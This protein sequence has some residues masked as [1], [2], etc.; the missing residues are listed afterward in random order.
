MTDRQIREDSSQKNLHNLESS[1]DSLA[2]RIPLEHCKILNSNLLDPIHLLEVNAKTGEQL[3]EKE[4]KRNRLT[5]QRK[6]YIIGIVLEKRFALKNEAVTRDKDGMTKCIRVGLHS[7]QLEDRYFEGITM[8][9]IEKLYTDLMSDEVFYC[10]FETFMHSYFVDVD[11]KRD[12]FIERDVYLSATSDL[13][14][15]AIPKASR[16]QGVFRY[17]NGNI[18]FNT[19]ESGSSKSPFL[20][21]YSK[22][23]ESLEP[24]KADF[25]HRH[26]KRE[27]L[28]NL[29][30]FETTI[31]TSKD[32]KQLFKM[33]NTLINLLSLDQKKLSNAITEAYD[34]NVSEYQEDT[35]T[36][37]LGSDVTSLNLQDYLA[38]QYIMSELKTSSKGY[39]HIR[40]NFVD[41]Y[42][43]KGVSKI[44]RA[45]AKASLDKVYLEHLKGQKFVTLKE[46]VADLFKKIDSWRK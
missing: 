1:A 40:N 27:D 15:R 19:R 23:L 6:D 12:L 17:K 34:K 28:K 21:I 38:V 24:S 26:F 29:I 14:K 46:D 43:P 8:S 18:E 33:D 42:C 11:I 10:T 4:V 41:R 32:F 25:F 3:S 9:N 45:R 31:K 30:R 39:E 13:N 7:K 16:N 22:E 5:I 20:K 37:A 35:T 36:E 2:L 44:K